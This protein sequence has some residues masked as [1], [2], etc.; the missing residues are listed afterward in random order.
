M[1]YLSRCIAAACIMG[2]PIL[3]QAEYNENLPDNSFIG[4]TFH[5]VR[6]DVLKQGDKDYYAIN[7]KNLVQF[8][9]WLHKSNWQPIS[10]KQLS[11]S[12]KTG[13]KLP[14]NAV[15]I[16]F[17]DGALSS[18]TQVYPLLKQYKMPAVFAIVTSWTNGNTKAAYEAY[19]QGN[20]MTW[21]QMREMSKSGYAE[22]VTHSDDMHK[23]I[24]ANP[25]KNEQPAAVTHQYFAKENRYETDAEYEERVFKD[26]TKSKAILEKELGQK[27][28]AVI[29]PYGAVNLQV[30]KIAEKAGLPLSFSLGKD[31]LNFP[32]DGT[33]QRGLAMGN[34]TVEELHE[35]MTS[36]LNYAALDHFD[37]MRSVSIDLNQL[38]APTLEQGNEELG[39]TLDQVS[40]L[41]SNTLILKVLKD[42]NNDGIYDQAYFPTTKLPVAQDLMNRASWQ[43]RTRVFNR[44]FAELPLYPDP[45]KPTLILDLVGDLIQ[46]NKNLDGTIIK[47]NNELECSLRSAN[48]LTENCKKVFEQTL[49]LV[50]GVE[51]RA[52]PYLNIS[53]THRL[54]LQL[55]LDAAHNPGLER[56]VAELISHVSLVNIEIDALK[57][58]DVL[59]GFIAQTRNFNAIEKAKIMVTLTSSHI[60]NEKQWKTIQKDLMSVQSTGIQKL[61][62]TDYSFKNAKLVQKYLYPVLSLNSSPLTYRDP[63]APKPKQAP[64]AKP[65]QSNPAVSGP[66][67]MTPAAPKVTEGAAK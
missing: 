23:G 43:T 28:D 50:D 61:G 18:Y 63:F 51:K 5:D 31:S 35:Q 21:D 10:L 53:N 20:L 52:R 24:L 47:A 14:E 38:Q 25:Q 22:F 46:N 2:M 34:P 36:S 7:T 15:L 8:F 62:I 27:V 44:V 33:F 26:L 9:E 37:Q 17:D 49:S 1:G 4:L 65:L 59:K 55:K 42:Q 60:E 64:V 16:C 12:L 57:Q 3:S 6:E 67:L 29:W 66:V 41:A 19:G 13:K 30:E 45:K 58:P 11:E 32:H 54:V 48:A 56:T 40:G 39:K